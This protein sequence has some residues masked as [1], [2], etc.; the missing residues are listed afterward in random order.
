MELKLNKNKHDNY[1]KKLFENIADYSNI[2]QKCN[3]KYGEKGRGSSIDGV[4]KDRIAIEIESRVSKQIRGA[5]LDLYLHYNPKKLLILIPVHMNNPTITKSQSE[6]LLERL[7]KTNNDFQVVIL[8][9]DGNNNQYCK[10]D[11]ETIKAALI[12]L[13]EKII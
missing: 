1:G 4:I 11:R 6:Y 10:E 13:G 12:K 7:C 3:T 8:N 9:G 5:I 2:Y